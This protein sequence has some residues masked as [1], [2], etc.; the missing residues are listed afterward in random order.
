MAVDWRV[1]GHA[2]PLLSCKGDSVLGEVAPFWPS[3]GKACALS[4][5][6]VPVVDSS[7]SRN[8][9]NAGSPSSILASHLGSIR[10][11]SAHLHRHHGHHSSQAHAAR[12]WVVVEATV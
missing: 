6:A 3:T 1:D 11:L 2:S 8:T 5:V 4:S 9:L 10:R 12:E 7:Q